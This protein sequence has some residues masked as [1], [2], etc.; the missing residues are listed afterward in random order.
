MSESRGPTAP[1]EKF[2]PGR[3]RVRIKCGFTVGL[4]LQ[5]PQSNTGLKIA[6]HERSLTMVLMAI[7]REAPL[8]HCFAME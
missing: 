4:G 7:H 3:L 1:F 5:T 6:S 2:H 8:L